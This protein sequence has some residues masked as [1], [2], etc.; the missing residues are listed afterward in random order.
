MPISA[1]DIQYRMSGG[2]SNND[3]AAALGGVESS[4]SF[5]DNA[6]FAD[7]SSADASSGKTYYRCF[8]VHNNHATLTYLAPHIWIQTQTSSGDTDIAIGLDAAGLN[9]TATTIADENTAPTGVSFSQPAS[10]G[11]GLSLGDMA[12]GDYYAV[13]VRYTVNASAASTTDT[14]AIR[15]KGDTNP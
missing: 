12:P 14:D 3:P 13:W 9:G 2:A 8:Y 10:E 11:A 15:V 6:I 5:V 4:N 7:V 1:S